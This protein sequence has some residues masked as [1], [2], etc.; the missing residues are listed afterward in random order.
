MSS[1]QKRNHLR[2][3]KSKR[4]SPVT[5]KARASNKLQFAGNYAANVR[6]IQDELNEI[7]SEISQQNRE[8]IKPNQNLI[9]RKDELMIEFRELSQESIDHVRDPLILD[10]QIRESQSVEDI[11]DVAK[12]SNTQ[13]IKVA[14]DKKKKIKEEKE[15]EKKP[16]KKSDGKKLS[17]ALFNSDVYIDDTG[18]DIKVMNDK[19]TFA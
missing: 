3:S 2:I 12:Q 7:N 4:A 13:R 9:A 18:S 11:Y 19:E 8:G 15:K 14:V 10:A 16:N 5:H 1:K 6:E 17:E